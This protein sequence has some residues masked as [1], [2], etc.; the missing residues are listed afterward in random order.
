MDALSQAY[1]RNS[2]LFDPQN[3]FKE[4]KLN[5][6]IL[7]QPFVPC[8]CSTLPKLY[9]NSIK[10]NMDSRWEYRPDYCSY[11]IYGTTNLY[12]LIMYVNACPSATEFTKRRYNFIL[13]PSLKDTVDLAMFSKINISLL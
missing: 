13:A 7:L 9:A 5:D 8:I 2:E 1:E 6:I 12:W 3:F 10:Y 11:D 4:F